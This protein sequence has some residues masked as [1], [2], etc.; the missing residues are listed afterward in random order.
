M[1]DYKNILM[2]NPIAKQI[3]HHLK[4]AIVLQEN[5]EFQMGKMINEGYIAKMYNCSVTPVRESLNMLR[6]D[7]LIVGNSYKSSSIVS[8][9]VKDIEDIFDV[10]EFLEVGALKKAFQSITEG[11]LGQLRDAQEKYRLA[12][13][14]FNEY[15]IIEHNRTFHDVIIHRANNRLLCEKLNSISEL[16]AMARAPIA[17]ERKA[18]G[19][20]ANLFLPVQEHWDIY[21]ALEREDLPAAEKA[22]AA[23][24]ERI[25]HDSC[26]Y[27]ER[28]A[29]E[30][31]RYNQK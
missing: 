2:R 9:S 5:P 21:Y 15:Q 12:Y 1:K 18:K 25:K 8:F 31:Y 11:D 17:Q 20:A 27:Y 7:G 10:R 4:E 19:A 3:Y 6:R 23:H 28:L 14:A 24:I 30:G 29:I 16:V 22:L 13:E 26:N